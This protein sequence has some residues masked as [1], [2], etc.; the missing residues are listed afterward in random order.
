[1]LPL[2]W[3]L[4]DSFSPHVE[5]WHLLRFTGLFRKKKK[6]R[7]AL[8][9]LAREELKRNKRGK[10]GKER[11]GRQRVSECDLLYENKKALAKERQ[12]KRS[13]KKD[14]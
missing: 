6:R 11:G 12:Q 4:S 8:P 1:V 13:K 9:V 5:V 14:K 7:R 2:F 10:E 3:L